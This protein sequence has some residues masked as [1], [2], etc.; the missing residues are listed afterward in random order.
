MIQDIKSVVSYSLNELNSIVQNY[1]YSKNDNSYQG[2][3]V[4]KNIEDDQLSGECWRPYLT[5]IKATDT[6]FNFRTNMQNEALNTYDIKVSNLGRVKVGNE[7]KRQYQNGFGWL[8]VNISQNIKYYVYR[9]VAEV[10]NVCPVENTYE[11][12]RDSYWTV[13]HITNNG[14]DNRPSNLIWLSKEQHNAISH[15]AQEKNELIR[16]EIEEKLKASLNKHIDKDSVLE[17]LEDILEFSKKPDKNIID[18]VLNK[19]V[20]IKDDYP[21]INWENCLTTAST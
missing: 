17:L 2:K 13:H 5:I 14:F 4:Y 3:P 16:K 21:N 15:K 10:W 20:L 19:Y 11:H 18:M 12:E 7:I 1:S 9:M 8:Y 6:D